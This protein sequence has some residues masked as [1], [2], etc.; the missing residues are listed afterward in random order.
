MK[1]GVCTDND[2]ATIP[3]VIV[4]TITQMAEEMDMASFAPVKW[5]SVCLPEAQGALSYLHH[6]RPADLAFSHEWSSG[7]YCA[8]ELWPKHPAFPPNPAP[9]ANTSANRYCYGQY[10][11]ARYKDS[12]MEFMRGGE[13]YSDHEYEHSTI[14]M[15]LWFESNADIHRFLECIGLERFIKLQQ[16]KRA[17]V[18]KIADELLV[19]QLAPHMSTTGK[20]LDMYLFLQKETDS[21]DSDAGTVY[22][23]SRMHAPSKRAVY[24][25]LLR[26]RIMQHDLKVPESCNP[27]FARLGDR[28]D[29]RI[30]TVFGKV[31]CK[32]IADV[33]KLKEALVHLHQDHSFSKAKEDWTKETADRYCECVEIEFNWIPRKF[34]ADMTALLSDIA[35]A[36]CAMK[37]IQCVVRKNEHVCR[38]RGH[39]Q[40]LKFIDVEQTVVP[41]AVLD[42]NGHAIET[43]CE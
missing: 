40:M 16:E 11:M 13:Y 8:P 38:V 41:T 27:L 18:K 5:E 36:V 1:L 3:E 37:K 43:I 17:T 29:A 32:N 14:L 12:Y 26:S 4:D 33:L 6:N 30:A 7:A 9:C 39:K 10:Y 22:L 21:S 23:K 24:M 31:P 2:M 35:N 15:K 28:F 34:D 42:D 20:S 19:R 25:C